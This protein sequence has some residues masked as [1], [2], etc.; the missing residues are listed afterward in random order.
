M[1]AEI[2]WREGV[3]EGNLRQRSKRISE[4]LDEFLFGGE[5]RCLSLSRVDAWDRHP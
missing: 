1:G 4:V 3:L 2:R 5:I